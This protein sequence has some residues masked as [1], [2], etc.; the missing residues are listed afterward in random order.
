MID[1]NEDVSKTFNDYEEESDI[2]FIKVLISK[3]HSWCGRTLSELAL[4]SDLLIVMIIRDNTTIVPNGSTKL[5]EGDTLVL[6]ARAFEDKGNIHVY[7]KVIGRNDKV[8]NMPLYKVSKPDGKLV[9]LIKRG[10]DT[11][12]PTGNTIILSGDTLVFAE[13]KKE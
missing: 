2:D 13:S 3:A 8:A 1:E 12:I 6:S 4:P 5:L 7:E 10:L 11:I 9:I